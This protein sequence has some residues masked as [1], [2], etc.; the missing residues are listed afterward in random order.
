M[1]K[2]NNLGIEENFVSMMKFK[3]HKRK[4][5]KFGSKDQT[6]TSIYQ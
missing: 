3:I 5:D 2:S 6:R 1:E 4:C